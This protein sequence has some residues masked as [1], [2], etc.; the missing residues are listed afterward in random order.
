M[1]NE[2]VSL[3]CQCGSVQGKLAVVPKAFFHVQCLCCDC[4]NFAKQLNNEAAIL[5]EYG[6]TE[7][8]QTYPAYMEITAGKEQIACLQ[9]HK[10]GLYRWYTRC[11]SM[12]IANTMKAAKTPFV[13]IAVN[14]MQFENE[15]QKLDI[16]GPITVKA[17]GKYA[18][19]QMPA[20]AHERFPLLFIP[21]I[22][23]FFVKGIFTQK[24]TPSPFFQHNQP[25]AK[26]QWV[27]DKMKQ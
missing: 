14:F 15:Q 9:L 24:H 26:P 23:A 3:R 20:G 18:R 1:S 19:G 11:C 17:F 27:K 5:D 7:L 25:I 12:P 16:I 21:K 2:I 13:G 22:L 8:F 10:K 4:Q 6:A